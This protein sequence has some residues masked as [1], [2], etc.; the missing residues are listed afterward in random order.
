M[1]GL[2]GDNLFLTRFEG[3]WVLVKLF[4][5]I[6]M[7]DEQTIR[8]K[9]ALS[10]CGRHVD[11]TTPCWEAKS[12]RP[13]GWQPSLQGSFHHAK[14]SLTAAKNKLFVLWPLLNCGTHVWNANV[15]L[16]DWSSLFLSLPPSPSLP[17]LGVPQWQHA[18]RLWGWTRYERP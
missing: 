3:G 16:L 14:Q 2:E 7:Q 13:E 15:L 4:L 17:T 10:C 8:A 12:Q 9:S 5:L 18:G 1:S 6:V 11:A